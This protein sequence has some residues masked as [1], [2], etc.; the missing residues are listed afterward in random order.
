MLPRLWQGVEG[1]SRAVMM[2]GAGLTGGDD[3]SSMALVLLIDPEKE[4]T[5]ILQ[6]GRIGESGESYAFNR[7][8]QLISESRFDDDLRDIGLI[9][10]DQ[11]GILNIEIRDP[12]GN[13]VEGFKPSRNR[14]AQPLTR[15][16]DSAIS[17]RGEFDL[18]GYND[19]RGVP[20]V[21]IWTW[22]EDLGLGITTEM[23]VAEA[24]KSIQQIRRQAYTTIFVV[25]ALLGG[26]T[27]I[28]V[29]SRV[30]VSIAQEAL[31][32]SMDQTSLVLENATDGI[33][34]IDDS[35]TVIRFNPA[36][37]DKA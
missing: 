34:T 20:V 12:G 10:P 36:C 33:L 5:E 15:M 17:G 22:V 11:R 14:S 35:Q 28:F 8:G 1:G 2:V 26:L 4:F 25:L 13:M 21:G 24:T 27:T 37:E 23:D 16:A 3:A 32:K 9:R 19:Y 18:D 29:R 31:Q 6:R 30:R 7:S